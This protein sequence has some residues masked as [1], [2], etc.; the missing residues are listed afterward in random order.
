MGEIDSDDL[1]SD[2]NFI[3]EDVGEIQ[4]NNSY[5]VVKT[6]GGVDSTALL[7]G[8]IVTAG[9]ATG[10]WQNASNVGGGL[11]IQNSYPLKKNLNVSGN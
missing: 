1:N 7:D 3:I 5:H 8:V 9:M 11:F 6:S 10:P 2:G 4:G